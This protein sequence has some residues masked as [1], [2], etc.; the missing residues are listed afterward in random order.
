[1][2]FQLQGTYKKTLGRINRKFDKFKLNC[3]TYIKI[4]ESAN[5][6]FDFRAKC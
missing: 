2:M 1:M 4:Y 3:T 5:V 6:D